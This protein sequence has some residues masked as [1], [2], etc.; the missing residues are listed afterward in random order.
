VLREILGNATVSRRQGESNS[1]LGAWHERHDGDKVLRI[2]SS[3]CGVISV[4]GNVVLTLRN[5][6]IKKHLF[7]LH[8]E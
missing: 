5:K 4:E 8:T 3:V 7:L 1:T 6:L 2:T